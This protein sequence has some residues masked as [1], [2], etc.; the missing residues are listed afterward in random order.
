MIILIHSSKTMLPPIGSG[1]K[2]LTQPQLLSRSIEIDKYLKTLSANKIGKIMSISKPLSLKTKNLIADWSAEPNKQCK[3]IDSFL[4]DIYSGLQAH[5]WTTE[6]LEY[7]NKTL[8]ILSGLYGILRPNDGIYPYR[9]EM[10]YKLP[11][12]KFSSLYKYWGESIV[13]TLPNSI[14]IVNLSAVEYSKVVT[15]FVDSNIVTTPTFNWLI[16]NR[17]TDVKDLASFNDI[18]YK[19]ST[20][21]SK[22]NFPAFVAKEFYGKGL[23]IRLQHK[24]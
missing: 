23:S 10:G 5:D 19:H 3:A 8:R 20:K 11:N 1:G 15:D 22:S 2:T 4:G 13:N 7:A 12:K 14:P 6:N 17:I 16:K 24:Q 18:G 9:L 21:L